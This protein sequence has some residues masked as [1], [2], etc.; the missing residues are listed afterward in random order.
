MFDLSRSQLPSP[1]LAAARTMLLDYFRA[2]AAA[3]PPERHLFRFERSMEFG[4]GEA[5]LLSQLCCQLAFPREDAKLRSYCSGDDPS[6]IELYPEWAT[7]RDI[8]YL[9]KAMM[10]PHVEHLPEMKPWAAADA[11]LSWKYKEASGDKPGVFIVHGFGGEMKATSWVDANGDNK[12]TR[13]SL[14]DRLLGKGGPKPRLQPS[15]ADASVVAGAPLNTEDDVLH[16]RHLPDFGGALRASDAEYLL[17]VLLS[18]YLRIPLLLRFFSDPTRTAALSRPELQ[19]L[20]D[21]AL[22]E[23]GEWQADAPKPLPK[24]IPAPDRTHLATRAGILFN[25]LTHSP[26]ASVSAVTAILDNALDLDAGRYT[27]HTHV[28]PASHP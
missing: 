22:F 7:F 14:L 5:S 24:L 15:A 10:A 23:P 8:A 26:S 20:L 3:V 17:Q 13:Q 19:Q 9:A 1:H 21:A 25:E 28:T 11:R 2:A 18:P 12:V 4:R 16:L 27:R 6:V